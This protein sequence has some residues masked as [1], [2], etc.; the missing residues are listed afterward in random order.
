MPFLFILLSCQF[1]AQDKSF[2]YQHYGPEEGLNNTNVWAIKQGG[3]GLMYFAT[4]NGVYTYDG[5][6]FV[7]LKARNLKSNYIRN[8]SFNKGNLL[9]SNDE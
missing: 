4:Q 1:K 2:T 8:I 9:I 7:K 5:Y 3:D 6:N